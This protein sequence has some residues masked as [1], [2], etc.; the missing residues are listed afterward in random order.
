MLYEPDKND[1]GMKYSPFKSC[2][3]PRP[4]AWIS[5]LSKTG[6]VNLAPFSQCNILGWDP[7]FVMFS[8]LTRPGGGRKDSVANAEDTGEF[9]F[10]MATYAMRDAV[11]LTS[12]IEEEGV[13]EMEKA[14]LTP[15]ASN[16]VKPPRVKESPINFECR[17]HQTIVLPS[18]TPGMYNS[19]VVGRVIGVHIDDDII[20]PDGKLDIVKARPL[21]RMGYMDYTSVTEVFE[22]LPEGTPE[23]TLRGMSG[24]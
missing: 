5:T 8:A 6:I 3:V 14:G 11:V 15:I 19:V 9:V 10:N 4:I 24:G 23:R 12:S 1:H 18:R 2:V 22:L 16:F 7:P 21:A 20:L 17:H 13:D